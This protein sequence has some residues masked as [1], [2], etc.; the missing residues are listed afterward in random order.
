[1][2][3]FL[4]TVDRYWGQFF[5]EEA[6]LVE[7]VSPFQRV[8]VFRNRLF[9]RVLTL[10]NIVQTTEADEHRYHEMLVHVPLMSLEAPRS[11]LIIGGGDGG[12]ARE[13][14]R[15]PVSSLVMVE[16][17][18]AVVAAS[19]DHLP[20]LHRGAFDD[21]RLDLILGDGIAY[22]TQ[23]EQRFDAI[24]V[25]ST[26]PDG[27]GEPLFTDAFYAAAA[28]R[29]TPGGLLVAQLG[30]PF[31]DGARFQA[32][33]RRLASAF[34][35]HGHYEISVPTYTGGPLGLGWGAADQDP[36]GIDEALLTD[37]LA[38]RGLGDLRYYS[39]ARHRAAFLSA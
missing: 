1:V 34:A 19:R 4:E 17:D 3:R 39:P 6:V 18:E 27:P 15:H 14:L 38:R 16:I 22:M 13:V 33:R 25:D 10:D 23:T 21:P 37:R 11:V 31:L 36:G 20:S 12:T 8:R 5:E 26:D 28:A 24:L 29:L 35:R 32:K 7:T 9:G 2:T 30:M